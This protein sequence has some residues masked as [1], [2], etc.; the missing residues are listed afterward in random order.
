M[1]FLCPKVSLYLYKSTISPCME[2]CCQ[3]CAGV[4]S[5][6]LELLDKLQKQIAGLMVFA[7]LAAS[8]EPLAHRRNVVS[9]VFSINLV[10]ILQNWLNWFQFLFV[11]GGLLIILID[12]VIL[13]EESVCQQLFSSHR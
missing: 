7:S 5:S 11:N 9:L 6:F 12:C 4:R 1:K 13:S 3:I 8:V 2:C 10:D